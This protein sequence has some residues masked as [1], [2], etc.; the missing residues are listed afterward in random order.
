VTELTAP[1]APSSRRRA[2]ADAQRRLAG[3][4][5]NH[6]TGRAARGRRLDRLTLGLG[7]AATLALLGWAAAYEAETSSLQ[8]LFV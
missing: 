2:A 8:S 4:D 3:N 7:L 6:E 5:P 1:Q